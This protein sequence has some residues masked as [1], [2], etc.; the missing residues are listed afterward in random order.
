MESRQA[1]PGNRTHPTE[2]GS[3]DRGMTAG[4]LPLNYQ[5]QQWVKSK[6]QVVWHFAQAILLL[7]T[8]CFLPVLPVDAQVKEVRRILI[9]SELG[10]GSPGVAAINQE[11]VSALQKSPYQIEFYSE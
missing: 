8:Y 5:S 3:S 7:S 2:Q 10:L 9:F 4:H 6:G 1:F 11:L